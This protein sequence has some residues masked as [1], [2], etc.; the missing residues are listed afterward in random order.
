MRLH[1]E[2]KA[3]LVIALILLGALNL[4][5][6][7][8]IEINWII[9]VLGLASAIF[10]GLMV[11]FFRNPHRTPPEGDIQ[12]ISPAD[13]TLVVIEETD[14]PEFFNDR[15]VQLSIFM[16]PLNVH[17]NRNVIGGTIKFFKYHPGKYLVAWHPKSS[18][19]NERTTVVYQNDQQTILVRQI[20]GAVARRIKWYI[21]EGDEV[22][23]GK[24]FGFIRF[25][26]RLDVFLPLN[27]DI[28]VSLG[29]KV[30]GGETVLATC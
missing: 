1:R 6:Y 2:G 16:S 18:T 11:N 13:G 25:G 12:V 15:R 26:S 27:A 17:V 28:K 19:E 7:R 21:N 30:V 23:K 4:V 8:F 22:A 9:Y 20:A 5:F 14:E 3:I 24:E 10:F 29:D